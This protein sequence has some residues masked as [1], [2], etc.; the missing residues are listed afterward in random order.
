M[1]LL[2]LSGFISSSLRPQQPTVKPPRGI[3][4]WGWVLVVL[5]PWGHAALCFPCPTLGC[6]AGALPTSR[7]PPALSYLCFSSF[8]PRT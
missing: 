3:E 7:K 4:V 5:Q 6:G 8:S 2:L 1:E